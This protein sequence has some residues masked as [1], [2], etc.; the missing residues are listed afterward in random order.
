MQHVM[1]SAPHRTR[2]LRGIAAAAACALAIVATS[3]A[4]A[5][6]R[7]PGAAGSAAADSTRPP[8]GGKSA[9]AGGGKD[10]HGVSFDAKAWK[11]PAESEMP[12]D[13]L[14]AAIRRGL[15]LITNTTDSLPAYAPGK[16]N[17]TSCHLDAGRN[18]EA[19]P[20]T[21]SHARFPKYMERTGA[22][23]TLADRVNYCFTRSL[24][25]TQLPVTSREMEDILTY[26]AFIS[27]GVPTG[28]KTPGADGLIK[29]ETLVGDTARGRVQFATTCA[30][31]HGAEG[32]GGA[33]RI[34]ALWGPKSYS[35]G[36]SMAREERAASFIWHNMPLGQGKSLTKQQAF[37]VSAYINSHA[38]PDSPGK[39]NDWPIGGA[40]ADVPYATAGH[41]AYKAPPVL[42]RRNPQGA[43]VPRPAPVSAR[44]TTLSPA[45]R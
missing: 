41:A 10:V 13:S 22:V 8:D 15:A 33:G 29:M 20:L 28:A 43:I 38:R 2:A 7:G 31:C 45:A 24:A 16:I 42:P 3:I 6:G 17:C 35:V 32:Q 5:D 25:G 36:A 11:P 14:G 18:V 21:G 9:A 37:D 44:R 1:S 34:P 12:D 39:Q 40:P 30:S 19:A 4:C 26:I 23:I 27:K